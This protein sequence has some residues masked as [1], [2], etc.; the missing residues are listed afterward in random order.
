MIIIISIISIISIIIII[1]IIIIIKVRFNP[2]LTENTPPLR[3]AHSPE[4]EYTPK[5][6][7]H[8]H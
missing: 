5:D 3:V 2:S 6:S 1:I 7:G 4:D 8:T